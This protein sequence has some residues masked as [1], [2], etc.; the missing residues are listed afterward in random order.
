MIRKGSFVKYVKP[1]G[2]FH[3]GKYLSVAD[4][5]ENRLVVYV[6]RTPKGKWTTTEIDVKDVEVVIE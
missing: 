1:H 3:E 4:R 2:K 6:S 5:N